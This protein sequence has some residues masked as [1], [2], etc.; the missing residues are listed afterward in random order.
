RPQTAAT[1][2]RA[3]AERDGSLWRAVAVSSSGA[4]AYIHAA[5]FPHHVEEGLLL[6]AFFL[7]SALGQAA[8][9]WLMARAVTRELLL[10][11]L[12]G[13]LALIALWAVTRTVGLP[14]GLLP[15]PEGMGAW[16]VCC[17]VWEWAVALA[18]AVGLTGDQRR[19]G[20][21]LGALGRHALLFL[22]VSVVVLAV[23]SLAVSHE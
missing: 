22:S 1:R 20:L 17:V 5:L 16:D 9:A 3:T 10:V 18:C 19:W 12:G 11:G 6:G 2:A 21:P 15:G 8:W 14:F 7:V 4:A 23:L 13:N